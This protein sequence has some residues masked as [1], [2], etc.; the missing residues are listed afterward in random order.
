MTFSAPSASGAMWPSRLA[1]IRSLVGPTSSRPRTAPIK[2]DALSTAANCS[3]H[4]TSSRTDPP[5]LRRLSNP[6]VSRALHALSA[7]ANGGSPSI[8]ETPVS[9]ATERASETSAVSISPSD[10]RIFET[11]PK[12]DQRRPSVRRSSGTHD[13]LRRSLNA[14]NPSR[15]SGP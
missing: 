1:T 7:S 8:L 13:G 14:L 12:W 3:A 9:V 11:D 4:S 15:A 2:G 6:L 5:S 10:A